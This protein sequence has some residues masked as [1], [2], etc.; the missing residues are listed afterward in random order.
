VAPVEGPAAPF[1]IEP[2]AL[3]L[4]NGVVLTQLAG[5]FQRRVL[6]LGFCISGESWNKAA[7]VGVGHKDRPRYETFLVCTRYDLFQFARLSAV[8]RR[9]G[10]VKSKGR[11]AVRLDSAR[12]LSNGLLAR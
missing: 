9:T 7:V 8:A 1:E 10:E 12:T 3:L 11:P 6:R 4:A 5:L 2:S